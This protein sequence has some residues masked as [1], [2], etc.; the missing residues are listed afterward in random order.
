LLLVLLSVAVAILARAGRLREPRFFPLAIIVLW[1][2]GTAAASAAARC[3]P[4]ASPQPQYGMFFVLFPIAVV[5]LT[6]HAATCRAQPLARGLASPFVAAPLLVAAIAVYAVGLD[7]GIAAARQFHREVTEA[8]ARI[9]RNPVV[10]YED[11]RP[12]FP[13]DRILK[14]H[15][16]YLRDRGFLK[17]PPDERP[18]NRRVS[19]HAQMT[20][21]KGVRVEGGRR[22]GIRLIAQTRDTYVTLVMN[23]PLPRDTSI[24]FRMQVADPGRTFLQWRDADGWH[25]PR[26]SRFRGRKIRGR[27]WFGFPDR[28]P[29]R[30]ELPI[31][32]IRVV[33]PPAPP[34]QTLA[35]FHGL[36]AWSR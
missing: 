23:P 33:F 31:L 26:E 16:P 3:W 24:A 30:Q 35:V 7:S 21:C 6:A 2:L 17:R 9:A 18:G 22:E 11:I 32:A 19:L 5:F 28:H 25:G 8:A 34:A 1:M 14:V 12:L 4:G 36:E 15:I 20:E 29:G 27:Y 13:D 10:T